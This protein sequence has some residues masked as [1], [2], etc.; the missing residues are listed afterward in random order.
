MCA[1]NKLPLAVNTIMV[2]FAARPG[3]ELMACSTSLASCKTVQFWQKLYAHAKLLINCYN[4]LAE[5]RFVNKRLPQINVRYVVPRCMCGYVCL[6]LF[7]YL[8]R[9]LRSVFLPCL[10]IFF[11]LLFVFDFPHSSTGNQILQEV[12]WLLPGQYWRSGCSAGS[13]VDQEG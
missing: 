2:C 5:C 13:G 11:S 3:S 9:L 6:C 7:C 1:W 8:C 10:I 4:C 12:R